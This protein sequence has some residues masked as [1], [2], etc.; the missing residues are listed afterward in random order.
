MLSR[1][2]VDIIKKSGVSYAG[3]C[4]VLNWGPN[5]IYHLQDK[6]R[7]GR[8]LCKLDHKEFRQLKEWVTIEEARQKAVE[9]KQAS[10]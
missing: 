6:S 1:Y 5:R 4:R 7:G 2:W 9:E 8:G 3:L 10:A